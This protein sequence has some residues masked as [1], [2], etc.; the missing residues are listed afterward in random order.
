MTF[1]NAMRAVAKDPHK[2]AMRVD[3]KEKPDRRVIFADSDGDFSCT[4][5]P[6][7]FSTDLV[8]NT[9]D[10]DAEWMLVTLTD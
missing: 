9:S 7:W 5:A 3:E 2:G 4:R 1:M 8:L 6:L 10:L